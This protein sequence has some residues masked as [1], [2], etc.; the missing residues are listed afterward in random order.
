M[1]TF[2]FVI[3]FTLIG[4]LFLCMII[5]AQKFNQL[6]DMEKK[7]GEIMAEIEEALSGYIMQIK[8]ENERLLQRI[9]SNDEMASLYVKES[10]EKPISSNASTFNQTFSYVEPV[11]TV[12]DFNELLRL[13]DQGVSPSDKINEKP[14]QEPVIKEKSMLEEISLL[15]Q[16]GKSVGEIAKILDK[17]KT[18]IELLLKFRQK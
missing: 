14:K 4:M 6:K 15:Q 13:D 7:Q 12:D 8:D 18:E 1:T 3:C 9:V 10:E 17:G 16:E 11:L 2:L 5:L